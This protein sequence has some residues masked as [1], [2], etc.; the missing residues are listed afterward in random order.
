MKPAVP[1]AKSRAMLLALCVGMTACASAAH[2]GA[3]PTEPEFV[4]GSNGWI[5]G[6]L[7]PGDQHGDTV[8]CHSAWRNHALRAEDPWVGTIGLRQ[9]LTS[10]CEL[11]VGIAL[12][13]SY[14][15]VQQSASLTARPD[16]LGIGLW[17]KIDF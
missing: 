10:D 9:E 5:S 4:V 7:L 6:A 11:G 17:L 12:P 2:D 1:S 16:D 13:S 3:R 8:G 15:G 14:F